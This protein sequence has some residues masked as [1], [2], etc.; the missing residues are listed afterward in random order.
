MRQVT[1]AEF[2]RLAKP[3]D[4]GCWVWQRPPNSRN[5]YGRLMWDHRLIMAHRLAYILTYG[6]IT[7][8]TM[9]V[10]HRCDN[11]PCINPDHL[12]LGTQLDNIADRVAKGRN[13]RGPQ[14]KAVAA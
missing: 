2:W 7:D 12:W 10:L 8:P 9:R 13:K 14:R 11:P 1:E 4:N 5:G 3:N 6:P